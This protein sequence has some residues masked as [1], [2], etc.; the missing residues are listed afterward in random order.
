MLAEGC[1]MQNTSLY[2]Q[3]APTFDSAELARD[4]LL[5]TMGAALSAVLY[6]QI[7]EPGLP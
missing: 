6:G 5:I 2:M 4:T 1:N 3:N 7:K